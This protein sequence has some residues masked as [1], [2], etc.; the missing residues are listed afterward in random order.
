MEAD[1]KGKIS[2]ISGPVIRSEGMSGSQMYENVQVGEERILGEVI[3]VEGNDAIIQVYE[4]TSGL[5]P[6]DPV[7]RTGQPLSVTLGPGIAGA[8]YDGVQR[9]LDKIAAI[10]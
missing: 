10:S 5:K 7:F 2:R 9:P 4:S 8:L 3:R 6:G 1:G